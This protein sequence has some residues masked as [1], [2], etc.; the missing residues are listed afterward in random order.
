MMKKIYTLLLFAVFTISAINAQTGIAIGSNNGSGGLYIGTNTHGPMSSVPTGASWNRHIYIYPAS[1]LASI[2]SGANIDSFFYFRTVGDPLNGNTGIEGNLAGTVTFKVYL[3]NTAVNNFTAAPSWSAET[4]AATLVY[5]ADPTAT[6]GNTTGFVRF[7]CAA[8]FTYSGGNLEVLVEYTQSAAAVNDVFWTYDNASGVP[9]YITGSEAFI[10]GTSGVPTNTL[11]TFNNLRHPAML[12]YYTYLA[13]VNPGLNFFTD[14]PGITCHSTAQTYAVELQNYGTDPIAIGAAG[15]TLDIA[16]PNAFNTTLYNTGI[17]APNG[18]ETITFSGINLNTAGVNDIAA[19]VN[20]AGD[21]VQINDS[22]FTTSYTASTINT[23]PALDDIEGN[24]APILEYVS[25]LAGGQYW[26]LNYFGRKNVDLADSLHPYSGNYFFYFNGWSAPDGSSTRLFSNCITLNH[27]D[28][29][30]SNNLSF[31]M[32]HDTSYVD[33]PDSLYISISE[34]KGVTWTRIAG[35]AR[36][37]AA[38]VFP[39]W[40]QETV[41]LSAYGCKTIQIG[42]EGVSHFGNIIGLEDVLINSTG[43]ASCA[44]PLTLLS[45]NAQKVNTSNKLTWK[46]SQELNTLKFVI[47]QSRD[48]RNFSTLGEIA[49]AG[50]SN[51]ERSYTYTHSL[52]VKGYNYYR[53]KMV[54]IDGRFTYSAV[55]MLQNL[56]TNEISSY[57]NPVKETMQVAINAASNDVATVQITDMS[58]KTV[59]TKVYSVAEGDNNISIDATAFT[60][61]SYILKVQLSSGVVVK[62]FTKL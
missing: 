35:F 9:A 36:Y 58:G 7:D 12:L 56:G 26:G 60:A 41:D 1:V 62:K 55:R 59:Y 50:N 30:T 47:E 37:D 4:A 52:P 39:D 16:G 25:T 20:M 40:R 42:F 32:S 54:D 31:W 44:V 45:F 15:V 38:F 18:T 3:K 8:P 17:I 49:A 61:G 27:S 34:D 11:S 28:D 13:A 19:Y 57:P 10:A 33:F 29:G 51:N 21:P 23:F 48:A 24:N 5:N 2:P 43:T 14:V 6:V 53:I 46:T 22:V